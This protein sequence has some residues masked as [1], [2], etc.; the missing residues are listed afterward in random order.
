[1]PGKNRFKEGLRSARRTLTKA[2]AFKAIWPSCRWG[3]H[4]LGSHVEASHMRGS[5]FDALH[6]CDPCAPMTRARHSHEEGVSLG[7]FWFYYTSIY[8]TVTFNSGTPEILM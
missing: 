4:C 1:M 7:R 8:K 2:G 5:H 3:S 6:S